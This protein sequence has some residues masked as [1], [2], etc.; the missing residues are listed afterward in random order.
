MDFER[1]N[2]RRRRYEIGFWVVLM[3]VNVVAN[4]MV[5]NLEIAR[6]DSGTEPWEPWVW[7]ISSGLTWLALIP[8]LLWF[9]GLFRLERARLGRHLL[10]HLAF[11]LPF[12]ALHVLGMIG[13]REIAYWWVGWNYN[14]GDWPREFFY[15]YLKDARTYFTLLLP[16]YLYR[17]VLLRWQ[18]EASL[19]DS[20]ETD[21]APADRFLVK[22]L[23]KEF[24]V[25]T[26][27]IEWLEASGNYV[28]LHA[29]GRVY[30]LRET[31]STMERRLRDRGFLRVHRSAIVNMDR[32]A[33]IEPF[34]TGDAQARLDTGAIVPVSRRYRAELRERLG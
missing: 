24:L 4:S 27:S 3:L 32:V 7:E 10:F 33:E 34:D 31:M 25:R 12:S 1:Y 22:K 15:E 19:P 30:P 13:L 16:V 9:D 26:E 2:A 28:N 14:F 17:F 6:G 23:G 20:A 18:G 11:T 8:V 29:N 5:E 21:S